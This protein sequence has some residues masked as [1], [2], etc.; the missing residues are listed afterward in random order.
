[1]THAQ[2]ITD[3]ATEVED[4]ADLHCILLPT[5]GTARERALSAAM[6]CFSSFANWDPS[7]VDVG[8]QFLALADALADAE[9]SRTPPIVHELRASDF[10]LSDP[11]HDAI[12]SL[13]TAPLL[14]PSPP[15]PSK[16]NGRR[17]VHRRMGC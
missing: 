16:R 6:D 12:G 3:L 10:W 8:H 1:M 13:A 7:A 17:E 5:K 4:L 9:Q 2:N 11:A 15:S 14:A